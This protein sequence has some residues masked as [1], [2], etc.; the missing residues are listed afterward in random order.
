MPVKTGKDSKG[1]FAQWGGSG[2]RYHYRC[3][4]VRARERA[5]KKAA[6]QGQAVRASGWKGK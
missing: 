6:K 4:D 2:K 5:K 3:G 1:C